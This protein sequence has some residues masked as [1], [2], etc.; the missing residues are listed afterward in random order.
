MSDS[1]SPS[2]PPSLDFYIVLPFTF[3][4]F[5]FLIRF[6]AGKHIRISL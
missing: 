6:H 2:L 5:T 3:F 1:N 4:R